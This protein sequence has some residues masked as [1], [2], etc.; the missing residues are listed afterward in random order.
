[1][2]KHILHCLTAAVLA[3]LCSAPAS[4]QPSPGADRPEVESS[5]AVDWLM[6]EPMSLFDWGVYRADERAR[7]LVQS[8]LVKDAF[9]G[10]ARYN[11]VER[12]LKIDMMFIG[13]PTHAKCIEKML[14][15]KGA[16]VN[17]KWTFEEQ[18]QAAPRVFAELFAHAG[19]VKGRRQPDNLGFELARGTDIRVT[20]L[21]GTSEGGYE[22]KARCVGTFFSA[23]VKPAPVP[24]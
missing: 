23:A 5:P 19:E 15:S 17:Y 22:M 1:M 13:E 9:G 6:A 2:K 21:V 7:S 8:P 16:F 3:A 18:T 12:R 10:S 20:M 24:R 14:L 4:A 11:A